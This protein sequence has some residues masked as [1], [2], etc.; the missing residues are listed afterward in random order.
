MLRGIAHASV[1]TVQVF[2]ML[3]LFEFCRQ[4]TLPTND[5]W[6]LA[7]R[8]AA[9]AARRALDRVAADG[10]PTSEVTAALD[11]IVDS[12]GEDSNC[13]KVPGAYPHAEWQGSRIEGLVI[14][15]VR[16]CVIICNM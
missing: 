4:H 16:C 14:A 1:S 7:G 5:T 9:A 3:E 15:Q 11:E 12:A 8:S 6:L 10:S 2:N 13:V